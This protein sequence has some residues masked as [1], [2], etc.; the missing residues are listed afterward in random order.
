MN[1]TLS[2][3]QNSIPHPPAVTLRAGIDPTRFRTKKEAQAALAAFEGEGITGLDTSII[4]YGRRN[5]IVALSYDGAV[6]GT[7]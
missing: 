5:W 3:E 4:E 6:V 2:M 7:L 1:Q